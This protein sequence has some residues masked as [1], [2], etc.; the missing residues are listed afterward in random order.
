MRTW[1]LVV[2]ACSAILVARIHS[3]TGCPRPRS[4]S[5][6]VWNTMS[7]DAQDAA[8]GGGERAPRMSLKA[9]IQHF[10]RQE[11]VDCGT[12]QRGTRI[13]DGSRRRHRSRN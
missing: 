6:S 4:I 9:H 3:Q 5:V 2:A 7:A 10:T 13:L 1:L 11:F 8:C 12:H